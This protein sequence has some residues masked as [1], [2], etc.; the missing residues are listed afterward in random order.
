MVW[1]EWGL[2]VGLLVLIVLIAW[3]LAAAIGASRWATQTRA[4][5][6]VL[7]SARQPQATARYD[8]EREL[9]GLP[10]PV[11]RFFR[12]VLSDGQAM[13]AA[14]TV[15]HRGRFN[16]GQARDLWRPFASRQRVL[17]QR[18]GF[19]WDGEVSLLPGLAVRVHDA[20]VQGQGMLRPALLGLF[21]LA[22]LRA[23]G[24][25]AR[26][27]LMRFAAEAAWYPTALLPSQGVRW[28]AVDDRSARATL[29]DGDLLL[30]LA[31]TFAADGTIESVRAQARAR[32]LAGRLVMTPWE[33]RWSNVQLRDGMRVPMTGEVAWLTPQGRK[34]YWRGTIESLHYEFAP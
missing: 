20:Y 31:F 2:R 7:E 19:V 13:V 24:E 8:A 1:V 17:M 15:A 10:E 32:M 22:D 33:G 34:P 6:A 11:Q 14:V 4:L 16:I 30:S 28:E 12:C 18:P 27:E 29:S 26:S 3:A 21:A 5:L 9:P 25:L 23:G